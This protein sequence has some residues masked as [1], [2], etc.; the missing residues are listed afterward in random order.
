M[1]LLFARGNAYQIVDAY[2]PSRAMPRPD[3][4]WSADGTDDIVD[5]IGWVRQEPSA[6]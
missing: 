4:A 2:T 3:A 1:T 6:T 5:A